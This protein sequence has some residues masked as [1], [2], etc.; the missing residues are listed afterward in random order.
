M[1]VS[2]IRVNWRRY[3][4]LEAVRLITELSIFTDAKYLYRET[5]RDWKNGELGESYNYSMISKT[6]AHPLFTL[7]CSLAMVLLQFFL[8]YLVL[9]FLCI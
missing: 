6:V 9:S 4:Q 5:G 7:F 3:M 8:Y 2:K 1:V